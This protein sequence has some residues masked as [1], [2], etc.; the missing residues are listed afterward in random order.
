[1]A[2]KKAA[3]K[4]P[5]VTKKPVPEPESSDEEEVTA[6]ASFFVGDD[7]ELGVIF[8]A[9]LSNSL[10]NRNV[11]TQLPVRQEAVTPAE[12]FSR[13]VTDNRV[14]AN[15]LLG[16]FR[17]LL[18]WWCKAYIRLTESLGLPTDDGEDY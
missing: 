16:G 7:A 2:G 12:D 8:T 5:K 3:R 18:S 4:A 9:N 10:R 15:G 17:V 14:L 6:S 1:M 11:L 13:F